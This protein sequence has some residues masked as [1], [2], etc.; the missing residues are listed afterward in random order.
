M[1]RA[2]YDTRNRAGLDMSPLP[3]SLCA[4]LYHVARVLP[5]ARATDTHDALGRRGVRVTGGGCALIFEPQAGALRSTTTGTFF[6]QGIAGTIVAQ[7]PVPNAFAIRRGL[8]PIR[9]L[10]ARPPTIT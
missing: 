4:A 6:D 2:H 7:A 3:G 10:A 1:R 9:S 5:S 8:S